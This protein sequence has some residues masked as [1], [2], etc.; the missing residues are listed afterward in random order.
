MANLDPIWNKKIKESDRALDPLGVNRVNDRMV[1]ELLQGITT[2][3]SR[4]RY[5][6]VYLWFIDQIHKIKPKADVS[7]FERMFYDMERIFMLSCVSHEEIET[8]KNH[9][10]VNGA[11]KGR[12]IW[13]ESTGKIPLDFTYMGNTLG[14]YGYYYQGPIQSLGLRQQLVDDEF[15]RSS[16]LGKK[17]IAPFDEIA[18]QTE[19][20]SLL[21]KNNTSKKSIQE[22]GT[23]L[24][25]CK[26]KDPETNE[27]N[28]LRQLF[29]AEN[30]NYYREAIFRRESLTLF[31]SIIQQ[32]NKKLVRLNTQ[33]FLSAC[34]FNQI[35]ENGNTFPIVIP[36]KLS[37]ISDKWK[38]VKA[39]DHLAYTL[40]S[41][42]QC[43]LQFLKT[44]NGAS[45]DEF[46]ETVFSDKLQREINSITNKANSKNSIL[47]N[48]LKAI[49]ELIISSNLQ[50]ANFADIEKTSK[51]F[52]EK[53]SI[54][55]SVNEHNC[56][57]NIEGELKTKK[58]D[59][60]KV[61]A[62]GVFV[63]L[64]TASR[65]FWRNTQRTPAWDWLSKLQRD[66]IG[67]KEFCS[68]IMSEFKTDQ[69]SFRE[70]IRS[71][72]KNRVIINHDKIYR[73]KLHSNSVQKNFFEKAGNNYRQV[74]ERKAEH[75]NIRFDSVVSLLND[76][77]LV[78]LS[79][80]TLECTVE[81]EKTI[82]RN[83][84]T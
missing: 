48:N 21:G 16:E 82:K 29:F 28:A 64:I 79:D 24:C 15:E 68:E 74:R 59:V 50:D 20:L 78:N 10:D 49:L 65:M 72:I 44:K 5:Y 18:K 83:T 58:P 34:Y 27:K 30:G 35:Q 81:G 9:K 6:S 26:L 4:A 40:D 56:I 67:V 13:K 55:S 17:I 43:F 39:Q 57:K 32:A 25:L 2:L 53:T 66:D 45:L 51:D 84:D 62:N 31:L 71:F 41:I 3:S 60:V 46:F 61:V 33:S 1:G 7:Q 14:G 69:T 11:D 8:K 54:L 73:A 19:F 12:K 22:I 76:L 80:N 42:L 23:K 63:V 77:D 37:D 36:T 75:R 52:D 38:I 70:F 47:D